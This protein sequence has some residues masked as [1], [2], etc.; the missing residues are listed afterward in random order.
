MRTGVC[1]RVDG[2][3]CKPPACCVGVEHKCRWQ[4]S[5]AVLPGGYFF[6][7]CLVLRNLLGGCQALGHG[8]RTGAM[9]SEACWR[10]R[11][12]SARGGLAVRVTGRVCAAG[13]EGTCG[14]GDGGGDPVRRGFNGPDNWLAGARAVRGLL[15][16]RGTRHAEGC[17]GEGSLAKGNVNGG[18]GLVLP[19]RGGGCC[20]AGW[21]A[22][23]LCDAGRLFGGSGPEKGC[24]VVRGAERRGPGVCRA[25]GQVV[26]CRVALRVM[27]IYIWVLRVYCASRVVC[28]QT[29]SIQRVVSP[30]GA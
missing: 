6:G 25:A 12:L 17:I 19:G 30:S 4:V 13:Q 26:G 1:T 7:G 14:A 9:A 15:L 27:V 10:I 2:N 5:G 18:W 24:V 21:E 28:L 20:I 29:S 22:A 16:H 3:M 23:G 8:L 11:V